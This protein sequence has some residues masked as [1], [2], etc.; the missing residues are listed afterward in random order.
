MA[1]SDGL[2]KLVVRAQEAEKRA[3][4]ATEMAKSDLEANRDFA[5]ERGKEQ[6]EDLRAVAEKGHEQISDAWKEMQIT[7]NHATAAL[8]EDVESRKAEHDLRKAQRGADRAE[9]DARFAIDFA[10]SAI[11]E[12]EY[13][14]L[15]AALARMEADEQSKEADKEAGGRV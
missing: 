13:A 8:R 14:V 5:R 15:D 7:W 3:G 12:A 6:A 4:A 1:G 9:D 10:Y 2:S 11:A